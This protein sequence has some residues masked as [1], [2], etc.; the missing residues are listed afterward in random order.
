MEL[1]EGE[2]FSWLDAHPYQQQGEN[3][4]HADDRKIIFFL[5]FL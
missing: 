5:F 1:P 3:F 4:V 2:P